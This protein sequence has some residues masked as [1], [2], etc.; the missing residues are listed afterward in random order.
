LKSPVRA[1]VFLD[2]LSQA[3]ANPRHLQQFG[4]IRPVEVNPVGGERAPFQLRGPAS[5]AQ[6]TAGVNY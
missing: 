3:V 2:P 4:P 1:A 5:P 6:T